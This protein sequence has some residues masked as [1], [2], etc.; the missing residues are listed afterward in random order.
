MPAEASLNAVGPA[1]IMPQASNR[2]RNRSAHFAHRLAFGLKWVAEVG[3]Q[4]SMAQPS[5]PLLMG[6]GARRRAVPY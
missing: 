2:V 1:M 6:G 5:V 4:S 3:A